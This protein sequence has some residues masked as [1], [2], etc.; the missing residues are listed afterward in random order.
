MMLWRPVLAEPP[1][2]TLAD[3]R[4]WVTIADVMDANEALDLKAA[5]ADRV[6]RD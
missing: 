6:R 5:M 3:L 1:I 4:Q 2:Y